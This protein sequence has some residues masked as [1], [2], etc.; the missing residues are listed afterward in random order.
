LNG[1][2]TPRFAI[3]KLIKRA[4]NRLSYRRTSKTYGISDEFDSN[5]DKNGMHKTQEDRIKEVGQ[6]TDAQIMGIIYK[7]NI[8]SMRDI[9]KKK[10]PSLNDFQ[11]ENSEL[12]EVVNIYLLAKNEFSSELHDD[13]DASKFWEET[14]GVIYLM[15]SKHGSKTNN[16]IRTI[17]DCFGITLIEK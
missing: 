12:K 13:T 2:L 9:F 6:L 17:C 1:Q 7:E 10:L 4:R 3:E 15:S 16:L 14:D 5:D 8:F 11:D